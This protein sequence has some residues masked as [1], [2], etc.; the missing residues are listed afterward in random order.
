MRSYEFVTEATPLVTAIAS[1]IGKSAQDSKSSSTTQPGT[2]TIT[3]Q[4]PGN[5]TTSAPTPTPDTQLTAT[6]LT[7]QQ[8][9]AALPAGK[10]FSY[11]GVNGQVE[12]LPPKSGENDIGLR[13]P[14]IGDVEVD[15]ETI[16]KLAGIAPK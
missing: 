7:P 5:G 11:P 10:K 15:P 8:I 9:Q 13:I 6:K 3:S 14:E 4:G 12:V 1:T 2:G 16:S